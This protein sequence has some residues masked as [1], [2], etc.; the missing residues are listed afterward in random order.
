MESAARFV[1]GL[2]RTIRAAHD[3]R[4]IPLGITL[5]F[6]PQQHCKWRFLSAP[7][8]RMK[9]FVK[10]GRMRRD[11]NMSDLMQQCLQK[12]RFAKL[13]RHCERDTDRMACLI[14]I[15]TGRTAAKHD[16]GTGEPS[17]K[18][19]GVQLIE[20]LVSFSNESRQP[21]KPEEVIAEIEMS[22]LRFWNAKL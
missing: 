9:H 7:S 4:I 1:S 16:L 15:S 17:S 14:I 3:D 18:I 22:G 8:D 13:D 21:E 20:C 11:K 12:F 10:F 2:P 6:R 5:S 19:P